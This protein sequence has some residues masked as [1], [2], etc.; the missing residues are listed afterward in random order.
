MTQRFPKE[1]RMGMGKIIK[2]LVNVQLLISSEL[3]KFRILKS[4]FHE[5]VS[6]PYKEKET[7]LGSSRSWSLQFN[8]FSFP[9]VNKSFTTTGMQDLHSRK[10]E[11][12]CQLEKLL[13]KFRQ[14]VWL[15]PFGK[16]CP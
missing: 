5:S 15:I 10:Y 4:L 14:S 3:M 13:L 2:A 9:M 8:S 16:N 12:T 7:L 11:I 1:Y 6:Q